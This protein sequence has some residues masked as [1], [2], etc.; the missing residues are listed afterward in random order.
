MPN[1]LRFFT[2][3]HS[4]LQRAREPFRHAFI[5]TREDGQRVFGYALL[6]PE[7]VTHPAVKATLRD[8]QKNLAGAPSDS[9]SNSRFFTMKVC[10]LC[11]SFGFSSPSLS[12]QAIGILSR[13]AFASG[14]FGWLEDLWCSFYR[15]ETGDLI[16]ESF[17]YN[18]LF[19][20][21]LADPGQCSVV[22]GPS[23]PHYFFRP[24]LFPLLLYSRLFFSESTFRCRCRSC[25]CVKLAPHLRVSSYSTLPPLHLR[26][27]Y[28]SIN[29]CIP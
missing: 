18:L 2:E 6:F 15:E 22:H 20:A 26:Q 12:P 13:W 1:G 11:D 25:R 9:D 7:E 10:C 16:I 4:L 28:S 19:E 14:F 17:V 8:Q 27:L 29:L 24:G 21:Y 5:I 3:T 23:S